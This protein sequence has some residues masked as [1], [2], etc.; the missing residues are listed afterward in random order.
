MKIVTLIARILLGIVFVVFGLNGFLNFIHGALPGDLAGQFLGAMIHSHYVWLVAGTQVVSGALLIANRYV[1]LAL[2]L[3]GAMLANILMFHLTMAR[4][5]IG[6]AIVCFILWLLVC[7][8]H[9]TALAPLFA[10]KPEASVREKVA[11]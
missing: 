6:L 7:I 10:S 3:A 1:A 11:V 2:V 4:A 8:R 5:D 9:R